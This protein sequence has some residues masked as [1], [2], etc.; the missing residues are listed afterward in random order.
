[1]GGGKAFA[2]TARAFRRRVLGQDSST[3]GVRVGDVRGALQAEPFLHDGRRDARPR[4][5]AQVVQRRAPQSRGLLDR[6]LADQPALDGFTN[7]VGLQE[8][9]PSPVVPTSPLVAAGL[10]SPK[11]GEVADG[12]PVPMDAGAPDDHRLQNRCRETAGPMP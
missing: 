3:V 7:G 2:G 1:M 10:V 12:S 9:Y 11:R 8:L 4:P 5:A 6:E